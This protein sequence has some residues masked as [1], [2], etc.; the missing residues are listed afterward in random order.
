MYLTKM[1]ELLTATEPTAILHTHCMS[2]EYISGIIVQNR[3]LELISTSDIKD[4]FTALDLLKILHTMSTLSDDKI[5]DN[6][7][8]KLDGLNVLFVCKYLTQADINMNTDGTIV[9]ETSDDIDMTSELYERFKDAANN[10]LDELDFFME[11]MEN[12]ITL[13]DIKK[14]L[15]EKYEYSKKFMQEHGLI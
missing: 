2:G 13:Q 5:N 6:T 4:S 15:P 8:I 10:Q 3:Y 12:G 1:I 11:L 14:F 7:Q 9:I